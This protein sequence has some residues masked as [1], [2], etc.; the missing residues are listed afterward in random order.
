MS[1]CRHIYLI[2]QAENI[3]PLLVPLSSVPH[4]NP[5]QALSWAW[6]PTSSIT[7][8]QSPRHHNLLLDYCRS[9]LTGLP[10]SIFTFSKAF[11]HT[12]DRMIFSKCKSVHSHSFDQNLC[13]SHNR[14]HGLQGT[15]GPDCCPLAVLISTK[16]CA[17]RFILDTLTILLFLKNASPP[18]IMTFALAILSAWNAPLLDHSF[19]VG[20]CSTV[21]FPYHSQKSPHI[22]CPPLLFI[23]SPYSPSFWDAFYYPTF[24]RRGIHAFIFH[25]LQM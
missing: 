3:R 19:H 6:Y 17:I 4:Y 10:A 5:Q 13:T 21:S 18:H 16:F 1:E 11:N 25:F 22:P 24:C 9:V 7:H 8:H 15:R 14:L 20:F 2:A 12:L 23:V